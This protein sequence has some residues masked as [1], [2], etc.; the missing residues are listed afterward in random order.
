MDQCPIYLTPKVTAVFRP[1]AIVNTPY[2]ASAAI[3]CV[4]SAC[5]FHPSESS[6]KMDFSPKFSTFHR[7]QCLNSM[8]KSNRAHILKDLVD[9]FD[10]NFDILCDSPKSADIE[11]LI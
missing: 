6:P 3:F 2:P 11:G 9:I 7:Q 1:A 8:P 5:S 10:G 4:Y